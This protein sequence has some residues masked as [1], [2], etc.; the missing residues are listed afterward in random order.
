[1]LG[2]NQL[3]LRLRRLIFES[4][5]SLSDYQQSV[6]RGT[7]ETILEISRISRDN[8]QKCLRD[9]NSLAEQLDGSGDPSGSDD[10]VNQIEEIYDLLSEIQLTWHLIEALSLNG[11]SFT[12]FSFITWLKVSLS[13]STLF[14]FA[15]L[16]F[17]NVFFFAG[18]CKA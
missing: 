10:T 8:Y 9:L 12:S 13:L 5:I 4:S 17:F 1:M 15:Y 11:S 18:K 6:A 16:T 7:D 14:S 2:S 3:K